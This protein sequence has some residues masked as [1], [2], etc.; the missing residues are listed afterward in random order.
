MTGHSSVLKGGLKLGLGQI[1]TQACSFVRSVIVARLISPENYGIAAAF[2]MTISL[3]EMVS[4]MSSDKLL[5]QA[6][7]GDDPALQK[8]TQLLQISRG[9]SGAAIFFLLAGPIS[10]L[11]GVPQAE[12][13][14]RSLTLLPLAKGFTHEDMN[15]LQREMK[16]GP[17]VLVSVGSSVLVTLLALPL[18]LWSRDYSAM[19]WILVLQTVSSSVGSHLVAERRYALAWNKNY[20]KR[21]F[22]FGWPLLVNGL[23]LYGI[24]EGDRVIIGSA[25][26]LFSNSTYTL[27]DLGV[28]SVAFALT[29]APTMIVANVST[30]LFLPFLARVKDSCLEFERRYLTC[31]R[32]VSLMAGVISIPFIFAGGRV[33]SLVYGHKYA[34]AAGFIGWLAAMWGIRIIRVAPTL[35]AMARGDTKAAMVSNTV[36]SLALVGMVLAAATGSRLAWIS[37]WGFGGELLALGMLV[38]RLKRFHAIP[39]TPCF[40]PFAVIGFGMVTAAVISIAQIKTFGWGA[41]FLGCLGLMVTTLLAMLFVVPQLRLDLR[42]LILTPMSSLWPRGV[43]AGAQV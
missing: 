3:F 28:Y 36:R 32:A 6:A 37:I 9:L 17:S 43:K 41:V 34:A 20:A 8:T 35:A 7:D 18:A 21:M 11:F 5:I 22:H 25:R 4:N 2:A 30:S 33:V 12:W 14:F 29:M 10:R 39:A 15:R 27:A 40:R 38:W 1:I 42:A 31:L 26:R 23:L 19:L 13:A 16:F 24:M